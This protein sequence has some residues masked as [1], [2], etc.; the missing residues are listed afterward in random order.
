[1]KCYNK[2]KSNKNLTQKKKK[3]KQEKEIVERICWKSNQYT[4]TIT[5]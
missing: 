1:M 3:K 2:M 4:T 5:T